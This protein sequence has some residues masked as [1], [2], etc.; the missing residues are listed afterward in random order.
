MKHVLLNCAKAM[1]ILLFAVPAFALAVGFAVIILPLLP[2][3]LL[4]DAVRKTI[5]QINEYE[6]NN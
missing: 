1:I 2:F 3:M 6:P 5:R 4:F